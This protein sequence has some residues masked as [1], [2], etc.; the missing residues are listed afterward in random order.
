MFIVQL[1]TV[2]TV[3]LWLYCYY[4]GGENRKNLSNCYST[5]F[6]IKSLDEQWTSKRRV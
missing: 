3:C 2:M 6:S 4:F 5:L 1:Y